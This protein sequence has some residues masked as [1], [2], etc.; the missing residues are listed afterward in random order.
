ME[1]DKPIVLHNNR[2]A[3]DAAAGSKRG[4]AALQLIDHLWGERRVLQWDLPDDCGNTPLFAVKSAECSAEKTREVI[5]FLI[6]KKADVTARAKNGSTPAICAVAWGGARA[7]KWL[8]LLIQEPAD[9][10]AADTKGYA[11]F[12]L[13]LL[14]FG[15]AK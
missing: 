4:L 9:L 7:E 8:H 1:P 2:T 10:L 12:G 15:S 5:E 6:A 11:I 14:F 13:N 3:I